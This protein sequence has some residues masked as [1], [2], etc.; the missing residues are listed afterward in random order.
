MTRSFCAHLLPVLLALSLAGCGSCERTEA[1]A[2]AAKPAADAPAAQAPAAA[3][4][5][6]QAEQPLAGQPPSA[7][8]P[9]CFVIVDADPDFGEPPLKVN[10]TTEIDCTAEPVTYSWDF[11]DGTTGGNEANPTHT[12]A[13]AGEYLAVVTVTAPDGGKGDD[14]IDIIVEEENE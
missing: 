14:E 12:Y 10:F 13:K 6:P 8:E 2:P 11:G 3:P 1:P 9:D 5:A 7:E 4:G